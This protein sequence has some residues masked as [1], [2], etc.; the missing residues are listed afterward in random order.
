MDT[1]TTTTDIEAELIDLYSLVEEK[2]EEIAKLKH[3]LTAAEKVKI[4]TEAENNDNARSSRP[5][6]SSTNKD[7][8]LKQCRTQL[9]ECKDKIVDLEARLKQS[10]LDQKALIEQKGGLEKKAEQM[11]TQFFNQRD[12]LQSTS[13]FAKDQSDDQYK[14]EVENQRLRN[15]VTDLETNEE[16]LIT[17]VDQLTADRD[18]LDRKC[19]AL[20]DDRD[21]LGLEFD[22]YIQGRSTD[23]DDRVEMEERMQAAVDENADLREEVRLSQEAYECEISSLQADLDKARRDSVAIEEQAALSYNAQK[24]KALESEVGNLRDEVRRVREDLKRCAA[25]KDR[26]ERDLEKT[27]KAL[28]DSGKECEDRIHEA[29][30]KER[31]QAQEVEVRLEA[32]AQREKDM[33]AARLDLQRQKDE[34]ALQLSRSEERNAWYEEGHGLADAVRY[35]KKLEADM[36]RRDH[37]VQQLQNRIEK[38][39]GRCKVLQKTVLLLKDKADLAHDPALEEDAVREAMLAHDNQFQAQNT[40]LSRQIHG[41]EAD[42]LAMMKQLRHNAA[43]ISEKGIK[44]LGLDAAQIQK[45][46]EFAS[47]V[48]DGSVNLPLDDRSRELKVRSVRVPYHR[49]GAA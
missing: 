25:D 41:L 29:L 32:A 21:R 7:R 30:V 42:R 20:A 15:A 26:A 23:K 12:S 34:V 1:T 48:R 5:S 46:M 33:D 37:D 43:E 22:R 16:D 40:E 38:E 11:Q 39:V 10:Q 45:V 14:L 36:F 13:K 9:S 28:A 35:Q 27:C 49:G 19:R 44:F 4:E 47:N 18:G 8:K 2:D 17:E 24:Q 6:R 3:D 31:M